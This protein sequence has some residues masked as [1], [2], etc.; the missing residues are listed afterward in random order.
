MTE[1]NFFGA[2][3]AAI[4]PAA[5]GLFNGI[6]ALADFLDQHRDKINIEGPM[7]RVNDPALQRPLSALVDALRA[8][9][10]AIRK[11]KQRLH[12]VTVGG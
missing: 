9:Q 2:R 6:L 8:K 1:R 10:D 3:P 5:I 11:A 7:I 4:L 12:A